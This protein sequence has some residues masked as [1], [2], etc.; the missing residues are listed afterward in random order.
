MRQRVAISA[1]PAI[2]SA[3]LPIFFMVTAWRTFR[4]LL[5]VC[6][7]NPDEPYRH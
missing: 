5:G 3:T 6:L 2:Y 1:L 4:A 7:L